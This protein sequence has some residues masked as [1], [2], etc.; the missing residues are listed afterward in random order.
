MSG[1]GQRSPS[2]SMKMKYI[3]NDN[4]PAPIMSAIGKNKILWPS[5]KT[6]IKSY[7]RWL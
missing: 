6:T 3:S 2:S 7:K 5:M 1:V 4:V